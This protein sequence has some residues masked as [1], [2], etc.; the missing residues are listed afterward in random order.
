MLIGCDSHR[1]PSDWGTPSDWDGEPDVHTPDHDRAPSHDRAAAPLPRLPR[2]HPEPRHAGRGP[3]AT[4]SMPSLIL[5]TLGNCR[6]VTSRILRKHVDQRSSKDAGQTREVAPQFRT[7]GYVDR[8]PD[9]WHGCP[10]DW[11]AFNENSD[12]VEAHHVLDEWFDHDPRREPSASP[13]RGHSFIN[14]LDLTI[15][16]PPIPGAATRRVDIV[17][18]WLPLSLLCTTPHRLAQDRRDNQNCRAVT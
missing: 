5:G 16:L 8:V 7:S 10:S 17:R 13:Q 11:G 18:R 15:K 1:T 14:C 6:G 9:G 2:H 4:R 3:N 12:W